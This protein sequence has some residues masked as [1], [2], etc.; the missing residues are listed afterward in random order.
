MLRSGGEPSRAAL[1]VLRLTSEPGMA[2]AVSV[3]SR[4]LRLMLPPVA[5]IVALISVISCG[6]P[7]GPREHELR[8]QIGPDSISCVGA[9]GPQKCLEV[10]ELVGGDAWGAWTPFFES[11]DGFEYEPGFVYDLRVA[12]RSIRNPPADGSSYAYRL[13]AIVSKVAP[14]A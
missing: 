6:Q 4:H 9:H 13:L 10:R 7:A 8:L 14:P 3:R 2:A 11:I 5:L 12:R 1:R